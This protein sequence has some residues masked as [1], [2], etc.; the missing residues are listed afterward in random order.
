MAHRFV[1][2]IYGLWRARQLKMVGIYPRCVAADRY[3][4]MRLAVEGEY[5]FVPRELFFR[6]F[7]RR[8]P[9]D[10]IV[11]SN[12]GYIS[13]MDRQRGHLFGGKPPLHAHFPTFY[14]AGRLIVELSMDPRKWVQGKGHLGLLMAMRYIRWRRRYAQLDVL[15]F[16]NRVVLRHSN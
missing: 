14:I 6:R 10:E 12:D 16:I 15:T 7:P 5:I 9:E 13:V 2:V 4:M 1:L 3:L 8:P 11:I